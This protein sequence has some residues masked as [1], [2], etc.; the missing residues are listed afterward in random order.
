MAEETLAVPQTAAAGTF[1]FTPL[2]IDGGVSD[3]GTGAR[4]A[5]GANPRT[6]AAQNPAAQGRAAQ[7]PLTLTPE[8][9][10]DM[11]TAE[12]DPEVAAA[13]ERLYSGR[14]AYRAVKRVFDIAFSVL[15]LVAFSWLF[16]VV[17][18]AIKID[19][20]KGPVFFGQER[21]GCD[22][23]RFRM[24]KF[25]SMCADAEARLEE[26][27]DSNE[28][29]GPVFKMVHDPRVT[30]VGRIIRKMSIDELPQFV[31]VLAGHISVV[32]P[33]P[34]L[35]CEVVAYTPRQEQRLLVKPGMTCYW[36]TRANRDAIS[37]DE[38]IE[39]DLLYIK[40]CSIWSDCKLVVQTVGVVLM[41]QGT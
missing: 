29:D 27:R 40:K 37:F 41:A 18:T 22:G 33:R 31:N 6:R 30:R 36:Q 26:L 34:A 9:A 23:R 15:I 4:S 20:P 28:K 24:W 8:E 2:V 5:A 39:L 17:A 7:Q 35:P 32:G 12:P 19:D 16:V 3:A 14:R 1:P 25:R 11:G 10:R 13:A 38:W 21:V